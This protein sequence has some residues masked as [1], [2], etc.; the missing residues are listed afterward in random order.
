L[1]YDDKNRRPVRIL[2]IATPADVADAKLD[3]GVYRA[4]RSPGRTTVLCEYVNGE[5]GTVLC[6][7]SN[8]LDDANGM[9]RSVVM[10]LILGSREGG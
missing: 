7:L 10:N 9:E 8:M 1:I 3:P 4:S 6:N 2:R 5:P